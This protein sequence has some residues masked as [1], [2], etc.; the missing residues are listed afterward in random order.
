MVAY[1]DKTTSSFVISPHFY[2]VENIHLKIY[3]YIS[4]YICSKIDA[5]G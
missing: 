1:F 4:R 2:V 5:Y 3:E